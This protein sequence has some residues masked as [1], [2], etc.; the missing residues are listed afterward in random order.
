MNAQMQFSGGYQNAPLDAAHAFRAAMAGTAR[1]GEIRALTDSDPSA[2]LSVA[3]GTLLLTLKVVAEPQRMTIARSAAMVGIFHDDETH[4]RVCDR[5]V[6][7]S[8]FT[9]GTAA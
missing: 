9:L 7:V 5:E 4:R 2:P 3:V 1:P 8:E 6:D